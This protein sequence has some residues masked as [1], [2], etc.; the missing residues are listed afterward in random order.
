MKQFNSRYVALIAVLCVAFGYAQDAEVT[1]PLPTP[2]LISSA[3]Q[4]ADGV[5]LNAL[6]K[7]A[8]V[9]AT[10]SNLAEPAELEGFGTLI[11]TLGASQK[12]LGAA[13]INTAQELERVDRLIQAARERGLAIL[14]VHLGGEGRRGP[15]SQP[16]LDAVSGRVDMLLVT[17]DGNTDGYFDGVAEANAIPLAVFQSVNE[18]AAHL[19]ALMR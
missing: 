3:G 13:G 5:V 6:L 2:V 18:V 12:A 14:G 1:Q 10:L 16:Y 19:G 9:E 11:I 4:S 15:L 17:A 8:Q 7:R